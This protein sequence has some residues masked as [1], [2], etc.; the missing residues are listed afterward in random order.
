MPWV[1]LR[2]YT[3]NR[4]TTT[5][6]LL[7]WTLTSVCFCFSLAECRS[8][9]RE[10]LKECWHFII[11]SQTPPGLH[12]SA[13]FGN[14]AVDW[15]NLKGRS[16]WPPRV[17]LLHSCTEY[18]AKIRSPHKLKYFQKIH[19][20]NSNGIF[21][22]RNKSD[23]FEYCLLSF[24]YALSNCFDYVWLC[25]LHL[26]CMWFARLSASLVNPVT[27]SLTHYSLTNSKTTA[28]TQAHK[29]HRTAPW[30]SFC[31]IAKPWVSNTKVMVVKINNNL[32]Q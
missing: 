24:P 2:C 17:R 6:H 15:F 27:R 1:H 13:L 21:E 3:S 12:S 30:C 32:M 9:A 16:S 18:E 22:A 7:S 23:W 26:V 25:L 14:A 10:H 11:I 8:F 5:W 29:A 31:S 20:K 19:T 4:T 28:Q